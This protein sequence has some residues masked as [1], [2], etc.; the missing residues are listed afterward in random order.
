MSLSAAPLLDDRGEPAGAV[1]VFRDVSRERELLTGIQRAHE[2]KSL[3]LANMSHEIRTPMN[4]ILG[5]TQLMQRDSELSARQR[6]HLDII[7]RSGELS[8]PW[9]FETWLALGNR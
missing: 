4:A 7:S 8:P 6:E 2:A 1:C 9:R 5:F 3:F